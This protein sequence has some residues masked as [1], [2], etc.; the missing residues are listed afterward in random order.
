MSDIEKFFSKFMKPKYKKITYLHPDFVKNFKSK[1]GSHEKKVNEKFFEA[2]MEIT[3][4]SFNTEE[5]RQMKFVDQSEDKIFPHY[6]YEVYDYA[7]NIDLSAG[8]FS[9][10]DMI[11]PA[12]PNVTIDMVN[13]GESK[14]LRFVI[15]RG[16]YVNPFKFEIETGKSLSCKR[17][18][19]TIEDRVAKCEED[20][21]VKIFY[22]IVEDNL[23]DKISNEKQRKAVERLLKNLFSVIPNSFINAEF[24]I[25]NGGV[26]MTI[27]FKSEIIPLRE[28]DFVC[29]LKDNSKLVRNVE[30]N[31]RDMKLFFKFA[32][33]TETKKRNFVDPEDRESKIRKL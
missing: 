21:F 13:N 24:T 33:L 26:G 12:S 17:R 27:T 25:R 30:L 23:T 1:Y 16:V 3:S 29:K 28:V 11:N 9:I 6:I 4:R 20:D 19:E 8:L 18:M 22:K 32:T 5:S 15:P 14:S 2:I 10:I 31:V 7:N